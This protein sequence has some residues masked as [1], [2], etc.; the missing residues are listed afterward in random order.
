MESTVVCKDGKILSASESTGGR[1]AA[2][3]MQTPDDEPELLE[4]KE[5]LLSR[6][7]LVAAASLIALLVIVY[8]M[9]TS[10]RTSSF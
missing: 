6:T 4:K 2:K 1:K 10:V 9:V 5:G 7:A 3:D 8:M